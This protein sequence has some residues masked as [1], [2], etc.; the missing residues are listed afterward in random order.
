[1]HRFSV[2]LQ[3][4]IIIKAL[5]SSTAPTR[6]TVDVLA[7]NPDRKIVAIKAVRKLTSLTLR[8]AKRIVV[9]EPPT[10]LP[11]TYPYEDAL[12]CVRA[13]NENG[14]DARIARF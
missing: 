2:T 3:W 5:N 7:Y 9:D 6:Y 11:G 13:L 14:N 1:M 4:P 10:T 8:D 12:E